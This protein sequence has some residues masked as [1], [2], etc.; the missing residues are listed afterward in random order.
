MRS[1]LESRV[2]ASAGRR[3]RPGFAEAQ[4][5]FQLSS[6]FTDVRVVSPAC[7]DLRPIRPSIAGDLV[8]PP[9]Q[10]CWRS[11][12][13]RGSSRHGGL[14]LR[15]SRQSRQ[16]DNSARPPDQL[17][18]PVIHAQLLMIHSVYE[19]RVTL[20]TKKIDAL[21]SG[22]LAAAYGYAVRPGSRAPAPMVHATS[23]HDPDMAGSLIEVMEC[24][25]SLAFES[26]AAP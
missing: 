21:G 17:R 9:F 14:P 19:I 11:R 20:S 3:G 7:A 13:G 23:I 18:P 10:R 6:W 5:R 16:Q 4:P 12:L 24:W 8:I 15:G 2:P 1:L 26:F 25:R 22:R